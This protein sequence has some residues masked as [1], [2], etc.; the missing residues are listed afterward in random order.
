M[1]VGN[2]RIELAVRNA[3]CVKCKLAQ[4]ADGN[5]RCRTAEG[6]HTAD[7]LIVSK[8]PLGGRARKELTT[9]LER[10]GFDMSK[11]AF[12][13]A[14]KCVTWQAEA[15]KTEMKECRS[16]LMDE[17]KF[18]KPQWV[19]CLGNEALYTVTGRSGITK[20]RGHVFPMADVH[21]GES[22]AYD[23]MAT[24]SPA[25]VY[26]NPGQKAGFEA[27]L[28]FL[29]NRCYRKVTDSSS[30]PTDDQYVPVMNKTTLRQAVEFLTSS[31]T[32][33]VD[34]ETSGFDE[35]TP[36][37]RIITMAITAVTDDDVKVF[38]IP[39]W[40]RESPWRRVWRKV[41]DII[42]RVIEAAKRKVIAHNGKFDL[43]WMRHFGSNLKLTFDTML[44]AHLLDENRPKGLKPL[45]RELI[46]APAWDISIGNSKD[47]PWYDMHKLKDILWYNAL[48]TWYTLGLY[49]IF[50]KQLI[51]RPRLLKLFTRLMVPASNEFVEIERYGMFLDQEQ[52]MTN[53]SIAKSEL[54]AI[55]TELIKLV[56]DDHPYV[57]RYK[58]GTIKESGV[59]FNPSNFSKWWLFDYLDLPVLA[60]GKPKEN[61]D[62][63]APSMA[64]AVMLELRERYP[65]AD[66]LLLRTGIVKNIQFFTSYLGLVDENSRCHTTFKLTGTSTG[67]LSSAK[68]DADKVTGIRANKIRGFNAQQV[69]RIKFVRGVWGAAPGNLF[70]EAD[71]SQVELRI[72]A[73]LADE[74]TMLHLYATGQDIHTAMAMRMT[75]KPWHGGK[76]DCGGC[77]TQEERKKAKA[78][79]FGF[80]YGM[81]WLKFISTAWLNYGVRVTEEEARSFRKA[82][83]DQFPVLPKW[84]ARQRR[85]A[86]KYG[87]VMTP[88]GRIRHLP[89]I[90]SLD[91]GVRAEAERQAINAPV[92]GFASDM[93]LWSLVRISEKFREQGLATR[94]VGAVH[95][96][97]NFE[98]PEEEM[99]VV[100]PII[101]NEMENLPLEEVFGVNLTVPIIADLKLGKRWGGAKELTPEQIY[102]WEGIPA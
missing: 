95:D 38:A 59:N 47:R 45:A 44:A 67:R 6:S 22:F 89:D 8:N 24:I 17:I 102:H 61:G 29:F 54:E 78:V 99:A 3:N 65:V 16:Y 19:L 21:E 71:Y 25:A 63:G 2:T 35:F 100:L 9:Y 79:N 91:D 92:Q 86:H 36:D 68:A 23:V 72:A 52:A 37:A 80:L 12:T 56:P 94:P 90:T 96:A 98:G 84:H 27:D 81:G 11:I 87:R 64:E 58:N 39:L 53:L 34:L 55:E 77:V 69:P 93:A 14:T 49:R 31:H 75:G 97:C 10:A 30:V 42:C 33:S 85:L 48:D 7:V 70:I 15:G 50:K 82:F 83:F 66:K 5:N 28:R 18:I 46:G 41:F 4:E 60:R 76:C 62:P 51:E 57:V 20:W 73:M 74:P 32:I 101:K 13:G 1:S 43:R 26:R 40:H 88:M